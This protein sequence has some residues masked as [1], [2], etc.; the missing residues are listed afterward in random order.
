MLLKVDM[1]NKK[2]LKELLGAHEILL[3]E[4]ALFLSYLSRRNLDFSNS[5]L[6]SGYLQNYQI[7]ET[8]EMDIERLKIESFADLEHVL[9]LLIPKDD[10]GLNGA[11]FTPSLIVDEII[12][13]LKP[14]VGDRCLDPS[15]GCGAFLLGLIRNFREEHSKSAKEIL[16]ENVFG[17]DILD[18]NIRRA[19]ML[20]AIFA[21]EEGEVIE[22][23]DLNLLRC[24]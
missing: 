10:R 22:S 18:Y 17:S 21:L 1:I 11:F 8:L 20:I 24:D 4:K 12:R 9:E 2:V 6:I 14:K 5:H 3:I 15:C 19:K 23:E 16:R 13:E 7:S